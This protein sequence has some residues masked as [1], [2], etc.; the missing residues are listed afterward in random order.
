[1]KQTQILTPCMA[2][3][4][5]LSGCAQKT[6]QEPAPEATADA[7]GKVLVA[8]YSKTGN[9]LE[10]AKQIRQF[11]GG[12][13]FV[14]EPVDAYPEDYKATIEQAKKEIEAGFQ[15]PLKNAVENLAQ[16]DTIFI[17]TPNWWSTIA[18]PVATFL[19]SHDLAGKRIIP[20]AT[21]GTG[22][23]AKTVDAIKALCPDSTFLE[24]KGI[25]GNNIKNA[26]DEVEAWLKTLGFVE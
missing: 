16:Y 9:T 25:A 24:A 21:H 18:P 12:D 20:F 14:I 22:G 3:L 26:A 2:V 7:A 17:G 5:I 11:V 10:M 8:V 6:R 4:A 15:P 19:S 23:L 1:M 13:L